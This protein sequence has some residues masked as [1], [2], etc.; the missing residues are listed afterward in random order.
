MGLASSNSQDF[1][2]LQLC[3]SLLDMVHNDG[4]P[5]MV[6]VMQK[7]LKI[8]CSTYTDLR[9]QFLIGGFLQYCVRVVSGFANDWLATFKRR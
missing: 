6:C 4:G 7:P 5:V 2:F 8:R 3:N 1:F 9:I